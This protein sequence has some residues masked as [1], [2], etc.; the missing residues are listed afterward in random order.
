MPSCKNKANVEIATE[1]NISV[2]FVDKNETNKPFLSYKNVEVSVTPIYQQTNQEKVAVI[3]NGL[4]DAQNG[5]ITCIGFNRD[6]TNPRLYYYQNNS[7]DSCYNVNTAK[8]GGRDIDLAS[9]TNNSIDERLFITKDDA[10]S[11]CG[12]FRV[13]LVNNTSIRREMEGYFSVAKKGRF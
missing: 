2:R 8:P 6:I 4:E 13:T 12:K 5:F 11:L 9:S 7:V 10:D 1:G 3:M